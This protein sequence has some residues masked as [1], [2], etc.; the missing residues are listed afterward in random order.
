MVAIA[1]DPCFLD[2]DD[3]GISLV[4][5]GDGIALVAA[6]VRIAPERPWCHLLLCD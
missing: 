4:V 3:I 5:V 6:S 1:D 2:K